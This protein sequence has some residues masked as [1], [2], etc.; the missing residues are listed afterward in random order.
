[1]RVLGPAQ[2]P[3]SRVIASLHQEPQGTT[4]RKVAC[5]RRESDKQARRVVEKTEL[6]NAVIWCDRS[7]PKA[8]FENSLKCILDR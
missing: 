6:V 8:S 2:A 5:D 7:D 4:V 3:G 1:M